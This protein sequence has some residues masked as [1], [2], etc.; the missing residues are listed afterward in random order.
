[1]RGVPGSLCCTRSTSRAC[2][3][4]SRTRK[5]FS[6]NRDTRPAAATSPIVTVLVICQHKRYLLRELPG[7]LHRM[8]EWSEG[9]GYVRLYDGY[10]L[11]VIE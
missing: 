10:A 1:M 6:P 5:S 11:A 4:S 7:G 2:F 8:E 3:P 9:P